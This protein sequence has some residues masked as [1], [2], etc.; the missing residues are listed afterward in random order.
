MTFQDRFRERTSFIGREGILSLIASSSTPID[1]TPSVSANTSFVNSF[2]SQIHSTQGNFF[3]PNPSSHMTIDPTLH[4]I[5]TIESPLR[6][7]RSFDAGKIKIHPK[8]LVLPENSLQTPTPQAKTRVTSSV[9]PHS[10]TINTRTVKPSLLLSNK[11][12]YLNN[13]NKSYKLKPRANEE[14]LSFDEKKRRAL[15]KSLDLSTSFSDGSKTPIHLNMP[16]RLPLIQK[17]ATPTAFP[18]TQALNTSHLEQYARLKYLRPIINFRN[19]KQEP[20]PVSTATS[21]NRPILNVTAIFIR[22]F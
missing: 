10:A 16:T 22:T 21:L 20:T 8:K 11:R 4:P 19:P 3:L 6:P 13:D 18:E 14:A 2:T 9:E 12:Y 1:K 5:S 17:A 15:S 7:K